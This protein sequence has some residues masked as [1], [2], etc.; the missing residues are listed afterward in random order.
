[1]THSLRNKIKSE[2]GY[3]IVSEKRDTL[4]LFT[5]LWCAT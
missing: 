4:K 2:S 5:M 1:M 3:K